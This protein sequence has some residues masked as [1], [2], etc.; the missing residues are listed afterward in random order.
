MEMSALK[1]PH[2]AL[3][4]DEID[5]YDDLCIT[6]VKEEK[7]S[8]A[9]LKSRIEKLETELAAT[10]K[11][12]DLEKKKCGLLSKQNVA[13]KR[14]IS[15]L[16]KTAKL[17]IDRNVKEVNRLR[18]V[19]K[20]NGKTSIEPST[21]KVRKTQ[22][23]RQTGNENTDRRRDHDKHRHRESEHRSGGSRSRGRDGGL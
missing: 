13:L 3:E 8:Y 15:C 7:E 14:N 17:E 12:L 6:N 4:N 19:A 23:E 9:E 21:I 10:K 18:T 2:D 1:R 16:F 5:L 20:E 22:D 11:R